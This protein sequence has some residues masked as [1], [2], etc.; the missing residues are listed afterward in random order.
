[1]IKCDLPDSRPLVANSM[2]GIG[3]EFAV[4]PADASTS[5]PASPSIETFATPQFGL[6][7][8]CQYTAVPTVLR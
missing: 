6:I 4:A 8:A 2:A 7:V 3:V 5:I 1:M